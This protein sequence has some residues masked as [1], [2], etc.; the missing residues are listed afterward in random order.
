MPILPE[1]KHRYPSNWK[2]ISL[3]VRQ[4]AGWRCEECGAWDGHPHPV[5]G[6]KV[7]L[8]VH[9][10]NAMPEDNSR[11]NL[12]ALCQRCHFKADMRLH[13]QNRRENRARRRRE[14]AEAAGQMRLL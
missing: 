9:H 4:D 10:I 11:D 1:N 13:I 12:V 8:T 6:S 7:V 14:A 3:E 2:Q 5:T